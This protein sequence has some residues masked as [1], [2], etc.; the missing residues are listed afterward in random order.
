ML[1]NSE[2]DEIS[3]NFVFIEKRW[4]RKEQVIDNIFAYTVAFDVIKESEDIES[5]FVK[6]CRQIND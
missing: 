1:K 5:N 6:K 4:N 3:I 2:N